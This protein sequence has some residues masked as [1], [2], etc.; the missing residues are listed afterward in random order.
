MSPNCDLHCRTPCP[1]PWCCWWLAWC[2]GGWC[3][4]GTPAGVGAGGAAGAGVRAGARA[5]VGERA[6]AGAG[7]R[8]GAGAGQ[9]EPDPGEGSVLGMELYV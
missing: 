4:T 1:G 5:G 3:S 6:G 9:V 2:R 8:T 7:V